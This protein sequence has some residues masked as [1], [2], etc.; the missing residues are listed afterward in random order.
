VD[1]PKSS[2]ARVTFA[3]ITSALVVALAV[4]AAPSAMPQ[5]TS[6]EQ[7]LVDPPVVTARLF[8]HGQTVRVSGAIPS[9]HEA[10]VVISDQGHGAVALKIKGRIWGVLWANTGEVNLISVP[11]LYLAATST[12]LS[13]LGDAAVLDHLAIGYDALQ[14]RSLMSP[15][16]S[17]DDRHRLFM[18]FVKLQERGELYAINEGGVHLELDSSGDNRFSADFFFP[19]DVPVGSYDVRLL[20]FA[21]DGGTLFASSKITVNQAGLAAW[22][23]SLARERGLFYGLLSVIVALAAG[24]ITGFVFDLGSKGGH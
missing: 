1:T 5:I 20:T 9:G 6:G 13:N 14:S 17:P 7:L 4:V 16:G 11:T 10:A 8:Y 22:I 12:D 21:E 15:A 2:G 23:S 18:E 19:P 24:L 3:M